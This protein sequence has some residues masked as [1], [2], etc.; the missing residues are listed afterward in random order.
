MGP[1][2]SNPVTKQCETRSLAISTPLFC[3]SPNPGTIFYY[4]H[5]GI[6]KRLGLVVVEQRLKEGAG[7][8]N[9]MD[10]GG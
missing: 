5:F 9:R 6:A 1:R 8:Q 10:K 7:A 2:L 4:E 3:N